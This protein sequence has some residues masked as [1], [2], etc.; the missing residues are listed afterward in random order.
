MGGFFNGRAL[1]SS[2]CATFQSRMTVFHSFLG[3]PLSI[4][5][6]QWLSFQIFHS[7]GCRPA[8][9][10][11]TCSLSTLLWWCWPP[12]SP[13]C[14]H[15]VSTLKGG[16][17]VGARGGRGVIRQPRVSKLQGIHAIRC[18]GA[19]HEQGLA[20]RVHTKLGHAANRPGREGVGWWVEG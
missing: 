5:M 6:R 2:H 8:H 18:H 1:Y 13:R 20:I 11:L 14:R 12:T 9:G 4:L 16:R 3:H 17:E 10:V 19:I 15:S 7:H